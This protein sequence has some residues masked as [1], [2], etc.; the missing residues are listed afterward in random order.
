[1]SLQRSP[2]VANKRCYYLTTSEFGTFPTSWGQSGNV[3]FGG[4]AD[5]AGRRSERRDGCNCKSRVFFDRQARGA[6]T[7]GYLGG[8]DI[9]E[10]GTLARLK[11]VRKTCVEPAIASHR[12][13]SSRPLATA[14]WSIRQR[15]RCGPLRGE[16]PIEF[17]VG[18]HVGWRAF[19]NAA[20]C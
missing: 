4:G 15:R 8:G 3:R 13:G 14:S 6:A 16:R 9:D 20:G 18:I 1:M 19:A 7:G 10:E 2:N 5:V 17:R 11:A 12:G